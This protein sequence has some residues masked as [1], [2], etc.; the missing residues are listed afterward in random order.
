MAELLRRVLRAGLILFGISV[1]V[2]LIFF[3]TP[4]A[5]PAARLAGRGASPETLAA[6]GT[7]TAW[8]SHCPSN[9]RP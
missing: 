9:T 1:L 6:V 3:A 2:F 4:G 8:T 7:N 5:D